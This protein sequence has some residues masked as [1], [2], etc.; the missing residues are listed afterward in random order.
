M[1]DRLLVNGGKRLSGDFQIQ[2]SK[3]ESFQVLCV[4]LL[5][6]EKV[7]IK[8]LPDITDVV[9]LIN[10]FKILNVEVEKL[11]EHTY[12]FCA[13]DLLSI[14]KVDFEILRDHINKLRGGVLILGPMLVRFKKAILPM[15][16]GD[17][18]GRRRL[19]TH[20]F[21]L[22]KLNVKSEFDEKLNSYVCTTEQ[23]KGDYVLLDESSVTGTAN[24]ILT[25]VLAQGKTTIYNAACEPHVQQLC[26]MLNKMG[27]KISGVGSNKLEIEGVS[28]LEGTE[29]IVCSDLLEIGSIIGL[30]A[31]TQSNINIKFN[32]FDAKWLYPITSRFQRIGIKMD[33]K[34]REIFV[35]GKEDYEIL[36]DLQKGSIIRIDDA[37]WPG[38]PTDLLAI[39][40]VTSLQAKGSILFYE[41]LY[42]SRLFFVD[43]LIAMGAKIILCDPHRAHVIGINREYP[44]KGMDISSP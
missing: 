19:D 4:C 1:N 3:N 22:A 14:N 41:K 39:L 8:N 13:K 15:P 40:L 34:P 2:G 43:I 37:V 30:S 7:L 35:H 36:S 27:A 18:I 31:L 5:T 24:I 26:L 9:N 32:D 42:E 10:I 6:K 25:A 38:F 44:L 16:G 28:S 11:N 17:K 29:H 33:I 23:L 21:G 20:F 12:S